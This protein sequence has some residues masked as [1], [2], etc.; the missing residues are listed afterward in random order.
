[1]ISGILDWRCSLN[2]A[3]IWYGI[4]AW[5]LSCGILKRG[6]SVN[7]VLFPVSQWLKSKKAKTNQMNQQVLAKFRLS[8]EFRH[9]AVKYRFGVARSTSLLQ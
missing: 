5:I 1:M 9:E 2:P 8:G 6:G 7:S 3:I 4:F